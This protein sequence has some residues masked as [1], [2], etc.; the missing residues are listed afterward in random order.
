MI[1]LE[2]VIQ[3]LVILLLRLLVEVSLPI[4]QLYPMLLLQLY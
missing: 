3:E 4:L 1:Q 2:L